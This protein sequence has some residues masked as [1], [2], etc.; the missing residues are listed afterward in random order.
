M[1]DLQPIHVITA[2]RKWDPQLLPN[3][4]LVHISHPINGR[5]LLVRYRLDIN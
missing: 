1:D 2:A 5:D 4:N 3:L